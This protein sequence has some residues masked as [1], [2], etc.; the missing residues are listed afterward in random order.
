MQQDQ[1]RA[2]GG[3][4]TITSLLALQLRPFLSPKPGT[5]QALEPTQG[6][7]EEVTPVF[8]VQATCQRLTDVGS[9]HL[10]SGWVSPRQSLRQGF[11][12]KWMSWG[13]PQETAAGREGRGRQGREGASDSVPGDRSISPSG[14]LCGGLW[15]HHPRV[16]PFPEGTAS[17]G[18]CPLTPSIIG[19]ELLPC[20]PSPEPAAHPGYAAQPILI[21]RQSPRAEQHRAGS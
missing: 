8:G 5:S 14:E 18:S 3:L 7:K 9:S 15:T 17:L 21:A 12:H 19:Q 2:P 20:G 13:Q 11:S 1:G 4:L 10:V 6:Q 16:T